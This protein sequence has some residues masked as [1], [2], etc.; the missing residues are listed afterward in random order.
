MIKG[1][2]GIIESSDASV[3]QKLLNSP[4]K[5]LN[6]GRYAPYVLQ[7]LTSLSLVYHVCKGPLDEL[8]V[9][10]MRVGN[11]VEPGASVPLHVTDTPE[12]QLFDVW[13]AH[14]SDRLTEQKLSGVAHHFLS[15]QL[16]GTSVPSTPISMDRVG[17]TYLEADF[18]KVYSGDGDDDSVGNRSSFV[19][20]VVFDVSV[21]R[22]SKLIRIY[23]TVCRIANPRL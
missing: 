1:S 4:W 13:P 7:N 2:L 18:S 14:S 19:V 9:S 3:N 17:L 20:P 8:D 12:E 15:I 11:S 10:E 21:Q 16:D 22:Y 23:S 5:H 6:A